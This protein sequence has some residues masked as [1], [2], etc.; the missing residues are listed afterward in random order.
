MLKNAELYNN[1]AQLAASAVLQDDR[2]AAWWEILTYGWVRDDTQLVR[3]ALHNLAEECFSEVSELSNR[4]VDFVVSSVIDTFKRKNAAYGNDTLANFYRVERDFGID[5][6]VG[7]ITRM[8]DK[9]SRIENL[10]DDPDLEK[11]G[12]A[13]QDTYTDL[14]AYALIAIMV[15]KDRGTYAGIE[16]YKYAESVVNVDDPVMKAGV[17]DE[18]RKYL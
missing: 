18:Y 15:I 8:S 17:I 12:E 13:L 9:M 5:P 11:V 6:M 16:G 1:F 7:L 4:S 14:G 10:L 2:L 3:V